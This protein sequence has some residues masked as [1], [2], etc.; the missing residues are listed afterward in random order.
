MGNNNNMRLTI[1]KHPE[2]MVNLLGSPYEF[3]F[4]FSK[5]YFSTVGTLV[6][7]KFH[8]MMQQR[9]VEVMT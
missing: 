7:L 8:N 2:F 6:H 3:D 5:L 1:L 4:V 9:Y